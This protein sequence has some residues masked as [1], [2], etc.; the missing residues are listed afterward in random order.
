MIV[1]TIT[2]VPLFPY[3]AHF[4]LA[5]WH[6]HTAVGVYRPRGHYTKCNKL[7]RSYLHEES[8][9]IQKAKHTKTYPK[10][11]TQKEIRLWLLE[12]RVAG[13][14]M[15]KGKWMKVMKG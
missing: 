8:K 5:P 13:L 11:Y 14:G 10:Y 12:V 15:L 3:F 4:H 7:D 2:D 6:H 9:K 1:D